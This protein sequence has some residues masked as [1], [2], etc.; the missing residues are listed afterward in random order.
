MSRDCFAEG[1]PC[2]CRWRVRRTVVQA[3]PLPCGNDRGIEW[4]RV[5]WRMVGLG[6]GAGGSMGVLTRAIG[7]GQRKKGRDY[8]PVE[9]AAFFFSNKP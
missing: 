3:S 7:A 1:T 9:R 8:K 4:C 6:E 2:R 5:V